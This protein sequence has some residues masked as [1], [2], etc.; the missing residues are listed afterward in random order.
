[1][2]DEIELFAFANPKLLECEAKVFLELFYFCKFLINFIFYLPHMEYEGSIRREN[3]CIAYFHVLGLFL[4]KKLDL[5]EKQNYRL[6]RAGA[7][8]VERKI[9]AS[10][11]A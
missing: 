7:V 4:V 11:T 10:S 6:S 9:C 8:A 5:R 3:F 2:L 1:M